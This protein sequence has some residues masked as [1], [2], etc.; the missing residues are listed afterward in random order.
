[1]AKLSDLP[2]ELVH[3]IIHHIWCSEPSASQ[4]PAD[5]HHMLDHTPINCAAEPKPR[6]HQ[7]RTPN[8]KSTAGTGDSPYRPPKSLEVSWPQ[9]RPVDSLNPA[10]TRSIP[11]LLNCVIQTMILTN[12]NLDK[13]ELSNL[14]KSC[15]NSMHTPKI[16]NLGFPHHDYDR[17]ALFRVLQ[18]C[19]S[20][21]LEY[22]ILESTNS[23]ESFSDPT[24][25][26]PL[27][28]PGL[29]DTVFNH[30]T[31]LK[32]LKT[33]SFM[34]TVATGRLFE[35]LLKSMVEL[36]WEYCHLPLS[37]L[38]KALSS[39]GGAENS[40]P[41]LKCCSVRS[42]YGWEPEEELVVKTALEMQG[43]CFPQQLGPEVWL[44]DLVPGWGRGAGSFF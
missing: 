42:R 28:S 23:R 17:Q 3:S 44:A 5:Q 22:L 16:A 9:G 2:P 4:N 24:S 26:D 33:L 14:L 21:N 40:L 32:N 34:G 31:A 30:P 43:A 7:E 15:G 36:A 35:C 38:V 12:Y 1:M 13:L 6:P 8:F 19:T 27:T 11:T 39:A 29:L 37:A 41:N 20:F 18:E 25:D 10:A